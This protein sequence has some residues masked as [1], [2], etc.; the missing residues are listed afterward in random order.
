MNIKSPVENSLLAITIHYSET[1]IAGEKNKAGNGGIVK[2]E[3]KDS[4]TARVTFT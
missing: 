2:Y 1:K 4:K 3:I